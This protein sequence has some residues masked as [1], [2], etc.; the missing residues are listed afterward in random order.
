MNYPVIAFDLLGTVLDL[1]GLDPV[2][3]AE[4]GGS[5]VRQEW[6]WEV[7]KL[8]FTLTAAGEYERF[9]VIAEA[10]LKIIEERHQQKP[11]KSRRKRVL[12]SLRELRPFADVKPALGRLQ[13]NGFHLMVL[14]N[15]EEKSAKE[16]LASA[17]LTAMFED[18]LSA[19]SV[20]RFKPALEPYRMAAE[21]WGVKPNKMLLVAAH[22]WDMRG[23]K[24]SGCGAGFV[25][26]EGQVLDEL[27]PTPDLVVWDFYQLADRLAP[28]KTAA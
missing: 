24:R 2:F 6:F 4:F 26:R 25:H 17:G 19:H 13:F 27:T 20:R 21:R 7:Q 12:E 5:R 9:S 16:A 18:V 28:L 15:S 14:T 3:R 8:M 22:S 23:A 1:S 10:A 11:S